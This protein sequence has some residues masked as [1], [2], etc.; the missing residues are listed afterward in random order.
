MKLD[1]LLGTL[2][3]VKKTGNGTWIACCPAHDDKSPSLT[4]KQTP[5]TILLHCFGGCDVESILGAVGMEF[6]DLYPEHDRTVSPTR[7]PARDVLEATRDHSLYVGACAA[8]MR[9]RPLT[10]EE[11]KRLIQSAEILQHAARMSL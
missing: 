11:T 4:I 1:Q 2:T 6:S 7:F 8:T 10:E 9:E 3:R 5:D